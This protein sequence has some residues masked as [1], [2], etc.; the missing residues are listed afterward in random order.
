MKWF[1]VTYFAV[2]AF[3]VRLIVFIFLTVDL[4]LFIIEGP[5]DYVIA[6]YYYYYEDSYF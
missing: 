2:I 4:N 5:F 6:S 3:E 1:C